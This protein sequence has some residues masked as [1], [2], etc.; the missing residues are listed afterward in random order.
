MDQSESFFWSLSTHIQLLRRI[1]AFGPSLSPGNEQAFYWGSAAAEA[2]GTRNYM[3]IKSQAA[4]HIIAALLNANDR[5]EFV[6]S[7][8]ALDRVLISGHYTIPLFHLPEQW[9]ARWKT[10]ERPDATARSGY[11]PETWWY[12]AKPKG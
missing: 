9:V 3:G 12:A 2:Q 6:S 11:L 7:V 1:V 8:R 4:D 5:D 10:I